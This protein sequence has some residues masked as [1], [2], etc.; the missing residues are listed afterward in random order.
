[1]TFKEL[2]FAERLN[3]MG[4]LAEGKFEEVTPWP[5][6]RYGLNRPPFPLQNVPRH[7]CYTPDYLTENYLVEVQGFGRS[8]EVHMKLDKLEALSWWHQQM[9]VLLFV[10][11]SMFDRHTFL[12]FHTIRDLCLQSQIKYFPEG[13]EY[14][15]IPADI[16]WGYGQEGISL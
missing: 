10:Y 7:I 9:E 5:Y 16:A 15:A 12:K 6:A 11:D 8:Q 14:Y 2:Q 4:D 1:M 13:K 3:K